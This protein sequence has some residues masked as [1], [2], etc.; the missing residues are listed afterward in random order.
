MHE[1]LNEIYLNNSIRS[2]LITVAVIAVV[3]LIKRYIGH[4]LASF[5]F[6]IFRK[7]W[8]QVDEA[9]YKK[10]VAHPLGLFLAVFITI[11]TLD[12]LRFPSVIEFE[13][14]HITFKQALRTIGTGIII[15]TFFSFLIKTTDF[16]GLVLKHRYIDDERRAHNQLVLFFKDFIKLLLGIIAVIVLLKYCFG[17]EVKSLVTGLSIVGA[18][19]A[20][21]LKENLENLIAS[22]IIFFDKPFTT[23]DL[24]KVNDITGT[25]EKIGLRTTRIRSEEK[26]YISVPN[27]QM[28]DSILDNLSERSQRRAIL[29]L[30]LDPSAKHDTIQDLLKGLK[31]IVSREDIQNSSVFVTDITPTSIIVTT[32]FY[33]GP[34][35]A[36]S[37]NALKQQVYMQAFQLLER[38]D[39]KTSGKSTNVNIVQSPVQPPPSKLF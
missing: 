39:V 9:S 8:K 28:A 2:Y 17:Y 6:H 23:G 32:T 38:M 12:K 34:V 14:Y 7:Q 15:I 1:H 10:L 18:A 22:F 11:A 37:F 3:F 24:V 36:D 35:P 5:I 21:A 4:Y 33:T 13:I 30:E 31:E 29:K 25:I 20:L 27:S 19:I 16:A 26:T